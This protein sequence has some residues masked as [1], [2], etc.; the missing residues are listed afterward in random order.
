[1]KP[2]TVVTCSK[3]GI[4]AVAYTTGDPARW[5]EGKALMVSWHGYRHEAGGFQ[6]A[7]SECLPCAYREPVR[8]APNRR[9]QI[10]DELARAGVRLAG[11]E[12]N[13]DELLE[14]AFLR[15]VADGSRPLALVS[16][17]EQDRAVRP[18]AASAGSAPS[19]AV[20][21][22]LERFERDAAAFHRETGMLA[23]GKDQPA[24][25]NGSP[26]DAE[27]MDAWAEWLRKRAEGERAPRA[28]SKSKPPKGQ[29]SL[30]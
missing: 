13:T 21:D 20:S 9:V 19:P 15:W 16:V 7:P 11:A 5:T 14:R 4:T 22:A 29:L 2:G 6:I 8:K 26:S 1:M 25:M 12:W 17:G 10:C 28:P 27:R 24:A 30:L 23:P 3:C 18:E